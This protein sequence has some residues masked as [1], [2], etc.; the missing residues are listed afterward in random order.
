MQSGGLDHKGAGYAFTC[1]SKKG[2]CVYKNHARA[3]D[4]DGS[5]SENTNTR[6]S[7]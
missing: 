5:L 4:G 6:D 7:W 2:K 3:G 1:K